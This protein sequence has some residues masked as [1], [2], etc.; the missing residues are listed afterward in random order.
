MNAT[1]MRPEII[2]GVFYGEINGED[3][4]PRGTPHAVA[5]VLEE[6]WRKTGFP[7]PEDESDCRLMYF[8]AASM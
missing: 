5:K 7:R 2:A 8:H 1:K 6:L 4:E 3:R